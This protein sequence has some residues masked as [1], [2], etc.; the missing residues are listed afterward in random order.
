[1]LDTHILLIEDEERIRTL[2]TKYLELEGYR[3]TALASGKYAIDVIQSDPPDLII[4]DIML[5]GDSG[6]ELCKKIREFSNIPIVF[7]TALAE[8]IDSLKGF[9]LGA[10]DYVTK[11]FSPSVL[12]A[13]ITAI[14]Q[15]TKSN[16]NDKVLTFAEISLNEKTRDVSVNNISVKL[17]HNEFSLLRALMN[18][19][20]RVF[21]RSALL[22]ITK[23]I[24]S[25]IYYRT[26]DT[27]IKNLRK[28]IAEANNGQHYVNSIYGVG[29]Q[30]IKEPHS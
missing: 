13:R 21:D 10:D 15:R 22:S 14:L 18:D 16:S 3:N 29:Y 26:I 1:M 17:T 28:K 30:L 27:H 2:V 24:D 11:P 9:K 12:M 7:L 8:E 25:E 4:L 19:P 6:L 23:Q 5:P 20:E